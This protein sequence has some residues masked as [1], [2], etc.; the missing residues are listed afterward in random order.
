MEIR[1]S[2]ARREKDTCSQSRQHQN[3]KPDKK[4]ARGGYGKRPYFPPSLYRNKIKVDFKKS[5]NFAISF[6]LLVSIT[7]SNPLLQ[8]S[9]SSKLTQPPTSPS[10]SSPPFSRSTLPRSGQAFPFGGKRKLSHENIFASDSYRELGE[11]AKPYSVANYHPTILQ[12][13]L[14]ALRSERNSSM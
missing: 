11:I 8:T 2:K 7:L 6:D 9:F 1:D 13:I 4:P 3:V 12:C 14:K 5:S 10:T